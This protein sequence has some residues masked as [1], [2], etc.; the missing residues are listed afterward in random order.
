MPV[1]V[2][3]PVGPRRRRLSRLESGAGEPRVGCERDQ[4]ARQGPSPGGLWPAAPGRD[5]RLSAS[6]ARVDPSTIFVSDLQCLA[7]GPR[8]QPSLDLPPPTFG[9]SPPPAMIAQHHHDR[10]LSL[11]CRVPPGS[12]VRGISQARLHFRL[13]LN[14]DS[15]P[16][17][18]GTVALPPA[19][20]LGY[21]TAA[22][23][24]P[25]V[26]SRLTVPVPGPGSSKQ[27]IARSMAPLWRV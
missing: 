15:G 26:P 14:V 16:R 18:T 17:P 19:A 8:L 27:S 23:P 6:E 24:G 13:C 3:D 4:P 9:R 12:P 25:A 7:S 5:A 20:L 2:A 22:R 10:C 11:P 1:T 21:A